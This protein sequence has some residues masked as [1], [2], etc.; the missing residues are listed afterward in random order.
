MGRIDEWSTIYNGFQSVSDFYSTTTTTTAS[1]SAATTDGNRRTDARSR[2]IRIR[3]LG[4]W[5][6]KRSFIVGIGIA[7]I[8]VSTTRRFG[9]S[10]EVRDGTK[11][12]AR[13]DEA[14]DQSST[15]ATEDGDVFA[16]VIADGEV[17]PLI[18]LWGG[19]GWRSLI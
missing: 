4:S 18:W 12:Q 17:S 8:I 11:Y 13:A 9:Q 7:E 1:A 6:E 3:Y 5:I 14:D 16:G 15:A 2:P 19:L 10:E